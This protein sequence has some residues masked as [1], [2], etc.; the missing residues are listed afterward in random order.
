MTTSRIDENFRRAILLETLKAV[1]ESKTAPPHSDIS[2]QYVDLAYAITD[3]VEA[4]EVKRMTAFECSYLDGQ[5]T[6]LE[7]FIETKT[8]RSV[9]SLIATSATTLTR[10]G[11]SST[12]AT[13]ATKLGEAMTGKA[14]ASVD[15]EL[16]KKTLD[17]FKA[18]RAEYD[19]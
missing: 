4:R 2:A 15:E 9:A 14:V 11:A 8:W 17:L 16:S 12:F 7:R 6:V 5:I 13:L 3:R 10:A 18:A 19:A 1:I